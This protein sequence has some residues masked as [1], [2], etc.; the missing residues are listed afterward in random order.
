V[1]TAKIGLQR[2]T[3]FTLRS[4]D[5]AVACP[6]SAP[7]RTLIQS[8]SSNESTVRD[9]QAAK[10]FSLRQLTSFRPEPPVVVVLELLRHPSSACVSTVPTAAHASRASPKPGCESIASSACRHRC[11]LK[12][13][14]DVPTVLP[15]VCAYLHKA[16][17]RASGIGSELRPHQP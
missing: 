7:Q 15:R 14:H 6:V 3:R 1:E 16:D 17:L 13:P 8:T 10:P 2:V 11:M 4:A 5:C 9:W 12:P